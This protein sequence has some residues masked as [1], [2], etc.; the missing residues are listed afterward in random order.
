[1]IFDLRIYLF[2]RVFSLFLIIIYFDY[3]LLVL[4]IIEIVVISISLYIYFLF[5]GAGIEVLFIY[6]LVFRVCE[7]VIG[8]SILVRVIRY[9]GEDYC[10]SLSLIKF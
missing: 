7:R 9:Y 5:G 4:I 3:F 8:L 6:Y 10:G 2:L 1:M